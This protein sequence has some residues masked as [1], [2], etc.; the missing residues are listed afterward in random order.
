[1]DK[2]LFSLVAIIFDLFIF[3]FLS[4][5]YIRLRS[6]ADYLSRFLFWI[7]LTQLLFFLMALSRY[8]SLSIG[9][10]N[11]LLYKNGVLTYLSFATS[12]CIIFASSYFDY[13]LDILK[14]LR[15]LKAKKIFALVVFF[16]ASCNLIA[17][18]YTEQYKNYI[19]IPDFILSIFSLIIFG[20]GVSS[21]FYERNMKGAAIVSSLV[22]FVVVIRQ[23]P[24]VYNVNESVEF[25][26]NSGPLALE[27]L[28]LVVPFIWLD[29]ELEE[30]DAKLDGVTDGSKEQVIEAE[31]AKNLVFV[32]PMMVLVNGKEVRM[33]S[34]PFY[35]LLYLA[36]ARAL[37]TAEYEGWINTNN[38]NDKTDIDH[39]RR[40]KIKKFFKD[41]N[42]NL[43]I[44]RIR[45][46]VFY[47]DISPKNIDI[48]ESLR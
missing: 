27:A 13:G 4:S 18:L 43:K 24:I 20:Y 1:M 12:T 47:L 11:T 17:V 31:D 25:I 33:E 9:Y 37:A 35:D 6:R 42:I 38:N 15:T 32:K 44:T 23:L 22:I 21:S 29:S 39:K 34:K 36:N 46:G 2:I 26:L 40:H 3:L 48:P 19:N 10:E 41:K 8:Y 28:F 16:L 7:S 30:A 5:F 14:I 45:S